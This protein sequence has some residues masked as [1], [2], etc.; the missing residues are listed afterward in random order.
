[1]P[2]QSR[3]RRR[4]PWTVTLCPGAHVGPAI[5]A[6]NR[7]EVACHLCFQ[8]KTLRDWIKGE[9]KRRGPCPWCGRNGYLIQLEKLGEVHAPLP[10]SAILLSFQPRIAALTRCTVLSRCFQYPLAACQRRADRIL[11]LRVNP[12]PAY[13][14][15]ALGAFLARPGDTGIDALLNN[16]S[17]TPSI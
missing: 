4:L 6:Y 7:D 15:A 3:A 14:V 16:C 10:G 8:D 17:Q 9:G 5:I 13:R 11:D 1:M 12:R 2:R